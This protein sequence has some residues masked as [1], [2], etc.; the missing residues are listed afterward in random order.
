MIFN[1][2]NTNKALLQKQILFQKGNNFPN[3]AN[4]RRQIPPKYEKKYGFIVVKRS[5]LVTHYQ[6]KKN[7][8]VRRCNWTEKL[9]V[10][11]PNFSAQL[12]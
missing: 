6:C 4:E 12:E 7:N 2:T 10:V 1:V 3:A 8:N 11:F 9:I 5:A